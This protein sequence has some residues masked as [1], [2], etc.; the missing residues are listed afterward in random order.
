VVGGK[1]LDTALEIKIEVTFALDFSK[2]KKRPTWTLSL[3]I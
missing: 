2:T 1:N 3:F